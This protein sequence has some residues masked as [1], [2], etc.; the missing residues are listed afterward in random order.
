[1]QFQLNIE[2][3]KYKEKIIFKMEKYM[4]STIEEYLKGKGCYQFLHPLLQQLQTSNGIVEFYFNVK[5]SRNRHKFKEE[6][7]SLKKKETENRKSGCV[8]SIQNQ[9][10]RKL[11]NI[12]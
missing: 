10:Y 6:T 1:M 7:P 4:D 8:K 2:N 11:I 12:F 9:R 3:T 5:E